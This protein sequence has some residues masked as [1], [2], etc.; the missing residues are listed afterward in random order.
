MI[1]H[2]AVSLDIDCAMDAIRKACLELLDCDRVTL[3]LIFEKQKEIRHVFMIVAIPYG[4]ISL[5]CLAHAR[6]MV[7]WQHARRCVI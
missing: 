6:C 3:Y 2:L 4:G 7:L 5:S 1:N